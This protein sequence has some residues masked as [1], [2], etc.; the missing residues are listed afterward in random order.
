MSAK[1]EPISDV[2]S[3]GV[4][5]HYLLLGHS[6]FAG[7]KYNEVLAENRA[8]DFNF[9][10]LKYKELPPNYF[11]LLTSMLEKNPKKRINAEEALKLP[12]F[13]DEMEE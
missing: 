4:I 13:C 11:N 2:F 10:N 8:C 9:K 7:K 6:I 5:A 1:S 12:I 3:A